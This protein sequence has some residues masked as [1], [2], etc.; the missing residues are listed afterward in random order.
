MIKDCGFLLIGLVSFASLTTALAERPAKDQIGHQV[1]FLKTR[2]HDNGSR[3]DVVERKFEASSGQKVS[4]ASS[5]LSRNH[6]RHYVVA[7]PTA[8]AASFGSSKHYTVRSGD[9]LWGISKRFG[10][11][12]A[13]LREANQ[14]SGSA[15][16][17]GQILA[18]PR[19]SA[20]VNKVPSTGAASP[21]IASSYTVRAGD[22][23]TAISTSHKV[24]V[25]RILT[26]N[27]LTADTIHPGQRLLLDGDEPRQSK[28]STGRK[29]VVRK[30]G[31]GYQ[32]NRA[33]TVAQ[34]D[35]LSSIARAHGTRVETLQKTNRI[36]DA[37]SLRTG[38]R[39]LIPG[40]P[41]QKHA[42]L[43]S[44]IASSHSSGL[45]K[46]SSP[47]KVLRPTEVRIPQ[48]NQISQKENPDENF[49]SYTLQAHDTLESVARTF[50]TTAAEL[51]RINGINQRSRTSKGKTLLIPVSGLFSDLSS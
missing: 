6:K 16:S 18:I 13:A 44:P 9:S 41:L 25:D 39:L 28:T 5:Q 14:L 2:A 46:T 27:G 36:Q 10:I 30:E 21:K 37:S 33:Y 7:K 32:V 47:T 51:R 17:A 24:S 42:A 4:K 45:R 43:P 11:N 26:L 15:I 22:T 12:L 19:A 38:Q 49:I 1:Y 34:G 31:R 3:F 29:A 20:A 8:A 35:T 23:L 50:Y 48:Q 40:A